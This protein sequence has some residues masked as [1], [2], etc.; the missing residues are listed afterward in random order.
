MSLRLPLLQFGLFHHKSS[1]KSNKKSSEIT[2]KKIIAKENEL[3]SLENTSKEALKFLKEY[4]PL[5][6]IQD[7]T[8]L[9]INYYEPSQEIA[10]IKNELQTLRKELNQTI[11]NE[12]AIYN[13][14]KSIRFMP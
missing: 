10:A 13:E 5:I 3:R 14:I 9:V 11:D 6:L 8:L 7:L 1:E 4:L 2:E 12:V